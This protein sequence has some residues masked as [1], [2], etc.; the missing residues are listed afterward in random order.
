MDDLM[1]DARAEITI[2]QSLKDTCRY[3]DGRQ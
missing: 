3:A 1:D 2:L